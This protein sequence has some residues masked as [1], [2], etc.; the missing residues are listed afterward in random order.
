MMPFTWSLLRGVLLGLVWWLVALCVNLVVSGADAKP[1]KGTRSGA[2]TLTADFA[3]T[4]TTDCISPCYVQFDAIDPTTGTDS[5]ATALE[6][7]E[8]DFTWSFGD[9]GT[10]GT[11]TWSY[12][13][14]AGTSSR[15]AARGPLAAHVFECASGST[16][17]YT[18]TLTARYGSTT[19]TKQRTVTVTDPDA[20]PEFAGAETVCYEEAPASWVGC[21]AGATQV[22][23]SDLNQL[24]TQIAAG[25]NRHLFN[26][27]DTFTTDSYVYVCNNGTAAGLGCVTAATNS[28]PGLIGAYGTGAKPKF[29]ASAAFSTAS[30]YG[31]IRVSGHYGR[32]MTDWRI[33]DIEFDGSLTTIP[34]YI[35]G[36]NAYGGISRLTILRVTSNAITIGIAAGS[37][38]LN[39]HNNSGGAS[40]M[41]H[42][43]WSEWGIVDHDITNVPHGNPAS[44]P[45]FQYGLFVSFDRS[46]VLGANLDGGAG[47]DNIAGISHRIRLQC[48]AKVIIADS[49]LRRPSGSGAHVLKVHSGDWVEDPGDPTDPYARTEPVGVCGNGDTEAGIG[50]GLGEGYTRWIVV[51]NNK[52]ESNYSPYPVSFGP[53]SGCTTTPPTQNRV[54]DV[55]F[56]RNWVA[57]TQDAGSGTRILNYEGTYGTIRNNLFDLSVTAAGGRHGPYVGKRT[58]A[59]TCEIDADNV[60]LYGNTINS[61]S[62]ATGAIGIKIET[63]STNI[64]AKNNLMYAPSDGTAAMFALQ[65]ANTSCGNSGQVSTVGTDPVFAGALSAIGGWALGALSP[66]DGTGCAMPVWR[67]FAGSLRSTTTPSVGAY[68]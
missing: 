62:G 27:G 14:F 42:S 25:R 36:I 45:T 56:E 57:M 38:T 66:Y 52:I 18:V 47:A 2:P 43:L 30:G 19:A 33:Q 50:M 21:P 29:Q 24:Q 8:V 15:N 34:G 61:G 4:R 28:G 44:T 20:A 63:G 40:T 49:D 3:A 6:F 31:I 58:A 22:E 41:G 17:V 10:S 9:T 26:R 53:H 64:T 51:A 68:E 46:A 5:T 67:D 59:G 1:L 60:A 23:T 16:C 12:G 55:L 65:A 32:N 35:S 48:G 37:D 54:R 13:A 7:H 39:S 11:G